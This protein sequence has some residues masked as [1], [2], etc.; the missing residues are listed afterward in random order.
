MARKK[1]NKKNTALVPY[2]EKAM[3]FN[4]ATSWLIPKRLKKVSDVVKKVG[5][6]ISTKMSEAAKRRAAAK[7]EKNRVTTIHGE[8]KG[9]TMKKTDTSPE[10]TTG[11]YYAKSEAK[12]A[13]KETLSRVKVGKKGNVRPGKTPVTTVT[14]SDKWEKQIAKIRNSDMSITKKKNAINEVNKQKESAGIRKIGQEKK[15]EHLKTEEGQKGYQQS[16]QKKMAI[17]KQ[18]KA[19]KKDEDEV[20]KYISGLNKR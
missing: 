1:K 13:Q 14:P 7:A 20:R 19:R 18:R 12:K 6:T 3:T 4:K 5:T 10:K 2:K 9:F 15:S 17:S 8:E 11:G 16:R